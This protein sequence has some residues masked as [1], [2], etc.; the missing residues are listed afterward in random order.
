[1]AGGTRELPFTS[2]TSSIPPY[3]R[4]FLPCLIPFFP[5]L[6][7]HSFHTPITGSRYF[8]EADQDRNFHDEQVVVGKVF[9]QCPEE[10]I[11]AACADQ[12]RKRDFHQ[13]AEHV[14]GQVFHH[15]EEQDVHADLDWNA[16]DEVTEQ[17][18]IHNMLFFHEDAKCKEEAGV[19]F[20]GIANRI[21]PWSDKEDEL[22]EE[23][24]GSGRPGGSGDESGHERTGEGQENTSE[25]EEEWWE[26]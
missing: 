13:V 2:Y 15:Q 8:H 19:V 6:Q 17:D 25:R 11:Q 4:L 5:V 21:L 24:T 16:Q 3:R 9:H 7:S 12:V 23:M 20:H 26:F 1:M 14:E 18:M 22:Q 10:H